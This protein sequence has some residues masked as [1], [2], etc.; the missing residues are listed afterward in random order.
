MKSCRG[1]PTNVAEMWLRQL[2]PP[3]PQEGTIRR[4]VHSIARRPCAVAHAGRSRGRPHHH[5]GAFE[6]PYEGSVRASARAIDPIETLRGLSHERGRNVAVR[7]RPPAGALKCVARLRV[8]MSP[9]AGVLKCV[10]RL[11]LRLR[12]PAGAL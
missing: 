5:N 8:R 11:K 6:R 9:P 12:V 2:H 10:A 4:G 1:C 7:L 3:E